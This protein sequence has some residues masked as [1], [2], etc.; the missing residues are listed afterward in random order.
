MPLPFDLA[1]AV[2]WTLRRPGSKVASCEVHF[3]PIG[4]EVR[5]LRDGTSLYSRIFQVGTEALAWAEE[6]QVRLVGE[7]WSAS[8]APFA[9]EPH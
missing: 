1:P 8:S 3:T 4:S 7:G 2:L 9:A 6:E 5:M